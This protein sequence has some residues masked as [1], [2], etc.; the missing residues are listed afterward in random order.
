MT[1]KRSQLCFWRLCAVLIAAAML[2]A[3]SSEPQYSEFHRLDPAGWAYGDTVSV[4]FPASDSIVTGTLCVALRHNNGYRFANLWLE[5]TAPAPD[6]GI[7][8]DTV[9]VPMADKFGRWYGGGFGTSFQLND[10]VARNLTIDMR[11]PLTVRHIMRLDTLTDIELI[12]LTF[13]N[14]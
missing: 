1:V 14:P 10:T 3:C 7:Y 2:T 13:S 8:R 6:G 5:I 11:R 9:N 4:S 12:G